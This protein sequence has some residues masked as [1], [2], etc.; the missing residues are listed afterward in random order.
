MWILCTIKTGMTFNRINY[1]LS[2]KLRTPVSP[3]ADPMCLWRCKIVESQGTEDCLILSVGPYSVIF[4]STK[5]WNAFKFC[6]M[7][8]WTLNVKLF[9]RKMIKSVKTNSF[10][11]HWK[12]TSIQGF[13][14]KKYCWGQE[15]VN[16]ESF[17]S[18]LCSQPPRYHTAVEKYLSTKLLLSFLGSTL[19][20]RPSRSAEPSSE[21]AEATSR[22]PKRPLK[23]QGTLTGGE[24][25]PIAVNSRGKDKAQ[26]GGC[27]TR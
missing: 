16:P 22:E 1:I 4:P 13:L 26:G 18:H 12:R 27:P 24:P 23:P 5:L 20:P 11:R 19:C 6:V 21:Q 14:L 10:L 17:S 3:H 25:S 7:C 8:F 15:W 9:R 2:S